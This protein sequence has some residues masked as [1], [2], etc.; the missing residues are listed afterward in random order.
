MALATGEVGPSCVDVLGLLDVAPLAPPL[1]VKL[2]GSVRVCQTSTDTHLGC[3]RAVREE[4]PHHPRYT[5]EWPLV[6]RQNLEFFI[7]TG[8]DLVLLV[9][10]DVRGHLLLG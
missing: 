3:R 5:Y 6:T 7:V 8:A 10:S 1:L 2:D 4:A 9:T